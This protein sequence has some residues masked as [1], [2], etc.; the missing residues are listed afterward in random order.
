MVNECYT[1]APY[2]IVDLSSKMQA[3]FLELA[4]S[5]SGQKYLKPVTM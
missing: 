4:I 5:L 3:S 1:I 2:P